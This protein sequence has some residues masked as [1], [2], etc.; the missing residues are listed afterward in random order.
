MTRSPLTIL[1][2]EDHPTIARQVV[3]FLDGLQW[4]TDHAASG[5]LAIELATREAYD[6]VLLDLN[7]PDMDGLE[8]CRAIKQ[9]APRNVPVLMLTAR[10]AFED[11]ARGFN[12]GADDY[13]TKPFDLREL[14]LRCEALARRSQ[15]HVSQEI[16]LGPLMLLQREK[17]ALYHNTPLSLTQIGFKLL[18]KLCSAYPQSVSRSA[19]TH[20][21]W[22]TSPPDS[23]A[24]KS[25]IYALRKQLEQAGAEQLIVTIPH[26]GYRLVLPDV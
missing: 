19:L 20:E 25:H 16:Q 12:E 2:V 10:D 22:G 1:V 18:L 5:A 21:V 13:L 3:D 24:L 9:R 17:R 11:K 14:A 26:L 7:L 15:L 6:V 8:V 23:D 4:H